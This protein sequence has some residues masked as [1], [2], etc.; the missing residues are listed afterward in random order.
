ML[1]TAIFFLSLY[2]RLRVRGVLVVVAAVVA[3]EE[4]LGVLLLLKNNLCV[5][6]QRLLTFLPHQTLHDRKPH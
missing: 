6:V 2:T 4:S 3:R 1:A 5:V